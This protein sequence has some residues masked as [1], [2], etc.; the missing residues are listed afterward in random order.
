VGGWQAIAIKVSLPPLQGKRIEKS[1]LMAGGG[2]RIYTTKKTIQK[3]NQVN[4]KQGFLVNCVLVRSLP[5][6]QG[7]FLENG[8]SRQFYKLFFGLALL[9]MLNIF[10]G[11][12]PDIVGRKIRATKQEIFKTY[13]T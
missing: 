11:N 3:S 10:I 9:S 5:P 7:Y 12:H 13:F 2:Q 6:Y 4:A 8:H 1:Y